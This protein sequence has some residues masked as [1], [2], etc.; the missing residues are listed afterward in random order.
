VGKGD[1][2]V[3]ETAGKV[4]G[5]LD[6]L[7]AA[8]DKLD[9]SLTNIQKIT[10][11]VEEGKGTV[12]RLIKDETLV[13][14]V[15]GVVRDT[16]GF[17]RQLTSTQTV[18][19]LRSEYNFLSNTIKTYVSVEIRPRPDKYYLIELI[20]DPRG[21]R[22]V[23]QRTVRSDDPS[24]PPL[25]REEIVETTDKFR[26]SFQFAKRISLATFR[27]GIKESTGGIGVDLAFFRDRIQLQTDLFD[28]AAN[29]W[30]RLKL[31]AAWEFFRR[32]YVVG[33]I[34]DVINSRPQ[35]GSGGGR[36]Y[37]IGAQVRFNDEDLKGLLLVGG[38]AIGAAA[39]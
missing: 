2:E 6:K 23:T 31:L 5:G 13:N 24:R 27:F 33:G 17:V 18:V 7:T 1:K 29:A 28:F 25:V 12:G 3:Q 9:Q 16:G 39:K 10:A 36:D 8:I 22:R 15:E 35:D 30:P 32:L 14:E 11:G 4:K 38:A 37:F 21:S 20:D 26:F 19:G 34:D